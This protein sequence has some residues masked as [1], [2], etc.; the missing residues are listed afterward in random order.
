MQG[1]EMKNLLSIFILLFFTSS[2]YSQTHKLS[3]MTP[4]VK[5]GYLLAAPTA[6]DL[7]YSSTEGENLDKYLD[8]NK[9]NFG[10]GLQ[11]LFTSSST[12]R[13][14]ADI[15]LQT[16]FSSKYDLGSSGGSIY[17]DYHI[18]NE[19]DLYVLGIVEFKLKHTP[20]FFQAG[21]GMHLVLWQWEYHYS[22]SYQSIN[23]VENDS[24]L[25]FGL[26]FL[27]GVNIPAG[28]MLLPIFV[29]FDQIFRYDSTITGSAGL[30][31]TF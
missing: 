19:Q 31:L 28:N 23:E 26:S 15:G 11:A 27:A 22:S 7:D 21:G 25:N 2:A 1:D 17:E 12:I 6:S 18:N 13:L 20:I 24:D 29:R 10:F 8:L 4:Y 14:G 3:V 16:L 9:I 30:G 5:V